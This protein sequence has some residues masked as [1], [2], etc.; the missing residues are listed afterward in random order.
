MR[1]LKQGRPVLDGNG[2]RDFLNCIPNLELELLKRG[3]RAALDGLQ[4]VSIGRAFSKVKESCLGMILQPGW[5]ETVQDFSRLYRQSNMSVTPK[6]FF[7][8]PLY[9]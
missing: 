5:R 1:S 6:V 9:E 4:V 2:S 3:E 8:L 7:N